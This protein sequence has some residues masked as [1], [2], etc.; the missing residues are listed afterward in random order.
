MY[1][2]HHSTS[3]DSFRYREKT[4]VERFEEHTDPLLRLE[5]F[6][7]RHYNMTEDN[8][9]QAED[10][11]KMSVLEHMRQAESK[12]KPS[13][14]EL[15]EDVYNE[16]PRNLKVQQEELHAHMAKYQKHYR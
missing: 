1:T 14:D 3:D 11:E 7:K 16:I 13:I 2:S 9:R 6:L 4:E 10:E 12:P 15:F 8:F 5:E